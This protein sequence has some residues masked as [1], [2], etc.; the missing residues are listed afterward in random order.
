MR[1]NLFRVLA[2]VSV[3]LFLAPAAWGNGVQGGQLEGVWNAEI[4]CEGL[5]G[6]ALDMP[7]D[8][9]KFEDKDLRLL[10]AQGSSSA[11]EFI[12][13]DLARKTLD[14][15]LID[16]EDPFP[17]LAGW[18]GWMN[19]SNLEMTKGQGSLGPF[20][21]TTP[22]SLSTLFAI[23]P[24]PGFPSDEFELGD[25]TMHIKKW[26]STAPDALGCDGKLE[27]AGSIWYPGLPMVVGGGSG[28]FA[29]CTIKA[30]RCPSNMEIPR[31]CWSWDPFFFP[32]P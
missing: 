4:K 5:E 28:A 30:K 9:I 2:A 15:L 18:C 29:T 13:E 16:P 1:T 24:P 12:G 11:V 8:P 17:V 31:F 3:V 27:M 26:E 19:T 22:V 20:A 21:A 25:S 23:D 14:V 32:T 10:I 6:P 7:G